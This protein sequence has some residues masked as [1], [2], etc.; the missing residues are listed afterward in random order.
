[1]FLA[2]IASWARNERIVSNAFVERVH[3]EIA[4]HDLIGRI[5]YYWDRQARGALSLQ[6]S[7]FGHGGGQ[8]KEV[9]WVVGSRAWVG[10]GYA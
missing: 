8:W 9:D 3:R 10:R 5:F 7:L 6:V 1:V 2:D 4:E